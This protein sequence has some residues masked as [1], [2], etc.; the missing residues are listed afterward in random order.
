MQENAK[1][2]IAGHAGLVGSALCRQ[3]QRLGYTNLLFK[4]KS[5]LNLEDEEAVKN[6]FEKERPDYV[7]LAAGKAGGISANS[8]YPAEFF[9]K[10]LRIQSNIIHYAYRSKV[11][12]ML[13]IGCSCLYPRHCPQPMKEEYLLTG[14]FELTSEAFSVTKLAGLKMC[15]AYNKQYKTNFICCISDNLYGPGDNFDSEDSHVVAA[16]ML[17]FYQAKEKKQKEV[18]LWGTGKTERSLLFVDDFANA[19]I[20]LMKHY[21]SEEVINIGSGEAISI[22]K[23]AA[24]IKEISGF[25]GGIKTDP[26]RPDGAPKKMLEISR[27]LSLGWKPST[28]L[29][30]GLIKT[31]DSYLSSLP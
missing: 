31:Y 2:Y 7:F 3:L 15:Q 17:K 18:L 11:K 10:N 14:P 19:C 13:F 22:M 25:L 16:L 23:L 21:G 4:T 1:I 26:G 8:T 9:Y 29:K 12:K 20:I 5:E 6:F 24:M 27:I 30:E 28:P